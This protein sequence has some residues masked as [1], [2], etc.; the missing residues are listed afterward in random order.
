MTEARA[1]S[2]PFADEQGGAFQRRLGLFDLTAMGVGGTIGAGIF[3]LTGVAAARYA[4]PAVIVSFGI[5]AF[6]CACAALCYAELASMIPRSGSAYAYSRATLGETIAWIVGWNLILEYLFA[7]ATVA[8]GWS[9]YFTSLLQVFGVIVPHAVD[10]APISCAGADCGFS[11]DL[12]NGPAALIV[13]AVMGLLLT[14]IRLSAAIVGVVTVFKVGVI[15]MVV[16]LGAPFIRAENYAP[17]VPP[18]EGAYGEFGWSGIVRAAGLVFFAYIGFDQVSSCAQE[19]KNPRRD[20]PLAILLSLLIC[21]VLYVAMALTMTGLAPYR[22]LDVANPVFVAIAGA[23]DGLSWLRP[24]IALG[25]TVGLSA[26]VLLSFY[27]QTRIF[28]AMAVDRLMPKQ[29]SHVEPR[30]GVPIFGTVFVGLVAALIAGIAP[31]EVLGELVSIGTLLAF[32]IVCAGV[33]ALRLSNPAAPRAFRAPLLWV[34]A[35]LGLA[36]CLYLMI[37]L[38]AATWTRFWIW[39]AV[40]LVTYAA[41]RAAR[42]LQ[43]KRA[44]PQTT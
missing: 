8:V 35:P 20:V 32:A 11:G 25:V 41:I 29:F 2:D 34:V 27:G 1:I 23:G 36:S 42:A 24:L 40:G 3:V 14:G 9:S 31:I 44:T 26:A 19:A 6:V 13:L 43:Q 10:A 33:M 22:D 39:L 15:L 37:S 5:A 7:T 4:G 18:N 17:F 38:P 12:V 21:T 30:R 16:I 28:H